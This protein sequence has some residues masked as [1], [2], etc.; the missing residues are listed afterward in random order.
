M[1]EHFLCQLF[2]DQCQLNSLR[3]DIGDY[4]TEQFKIMG[5]DSYQNLTA[6]QFQSSCTT[7]S[8]LY[9]RL[10]YTYL[11]EHLIECSPSLERLTVEFNRTLNIKPRS[12]SFIKKL[13]KSNGNWCNKVR[14]RN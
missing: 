6:N 9:I 11:L 3:L 4:T 2:S 8:R 10:Q 14:K 13:C 12:I 7:L 1:F 5:T